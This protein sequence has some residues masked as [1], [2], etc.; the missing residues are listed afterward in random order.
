MENPAQ[1][2]TQKCKEHNV[3]MIRLWFTDVLGML[4]GFEITV[5]ELDRAFE[6]GMGFD[7]SSIE[8]FVRIDESDM[9][10]I[11]DASTFRI[12]PSLADGDAVVAA[13]FCDICTPDR[14][15]YDSDPR[16]VLKKNLA[17]AKE[18]GY[19]FYVGPELEFFY[20]KS[21]DNPEPLDRGGYFDLG[22]LDTGSGIR[23]KTVQALEQVGIQVEYAHH[24]VG[25]S[26]HEIDLRYDEGLKMADH[27]MLYRQVVKDVAHEHGVYATFMPKPLFGHNGSGMHT[28]MS[29]FEGEKNAFYQSDS[30]DYLSETAKQFIAGLIKHAPE[31]TVVT[32]QWINS[33]KRLVP[34]YEAPIYLTWARRNR[35]DLIRVPQYSPGKEKSTRIEYRCPDPACNPYLAFAVML[36]AGLEGIKNKYDCPPPLEENVYLYDENKRREKKIRH[37]PT[38]LYG[39]ILEAEKSD[40]MKKALGEDLLQKFLRNKR[41]EWENYRARITPYE[42]AEYLPRL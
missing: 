15:P 4:K 10:A 29:L 5:D 37:L 31:I 2:L 16:Q 13:M 27:A 3:D 25:P 30:E 42:M 19:T 22:T 14:K 24:E 1:E 21:A 36:A 39:A 33:Y 40:L 8:G 11:P 34:G 23:I 9:L 38:D 28:H 17:E 20:F 6:L 32:N 35:S 12:L 7:G 18:M 26:Q 41:A